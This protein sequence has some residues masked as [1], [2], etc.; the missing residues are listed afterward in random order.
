MRILLACSFLGLAALAI[1]DYRQ[2][3]ERRRP[4]D[5]F[6]VRYTIDERR[7]EAAWSVRTAYSSDDAALAAGS[8]AAA[9]ASEGTNLRDLSPEL[10]QRWLQAM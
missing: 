2:D 5:A 9:D 10:Q 3:L 1:A 8:A 4:I 6:V 7:P